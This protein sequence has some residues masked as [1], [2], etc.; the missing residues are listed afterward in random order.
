MII[1][2]VDICNMALDHLNQRDITSLDENTKQAKIC[3]R[4]FDVTRRTLLTNLNASFSIDR[5]VL[6]EIKNCIPIYGYEKAYALPKDCLQVLN[7]GSP[8]ENE[9]YQ[10]ENG[11]FYCDKKNDKEL[12]QIRYIKDVV[13]VSQY[14][15]EFVDLFAI[16]LAEQICVPLTEDLEKRNML[17]QLKKEKYIECSTK[18]GRDNRVTVV[19]VPRYRMSKLSPEIMDADYQLK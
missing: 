19:N 3:A 8:L 9:L 17:R 10:I 13:D 18:Y 14:D 11:C 12:I 7:L 1:S 15:S 5:A 6:P 2:D 4:W 16:A